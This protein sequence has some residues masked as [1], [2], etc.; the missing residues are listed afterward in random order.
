[1]ASVLCFACGRRV[2]S[3]LTHDGQH[4]IGCKHC[5]FARPADNEQTILAKL[6]RQALPIFTR[7]GRP[8]LE[9]VRPVAVEV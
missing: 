7:M 4:A 9:V 2:H 6:A 5:G 1:M 8:K 3:F